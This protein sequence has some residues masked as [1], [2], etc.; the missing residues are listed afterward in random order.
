MIHSEDLF[1]QS[2][3]EMTKTGEV[4]EWEKIGKSLQ[5]QIL[6]HM[7]V[8]QFGDAINLPTL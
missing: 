8:C 4:K 1:G 6:L 3:K 7:S 2:L 5:L